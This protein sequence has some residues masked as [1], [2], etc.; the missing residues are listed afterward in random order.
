MEANLGLKVCWACLTP[1]ITS[2][3]TLLSDDNG[4]SARKLYEVTGFKVSTFAIKIS[5]LII[6]ELQ[7]CAN[8]DSDAAICDTC[9]DVLNKSD[10]LRKKI[11]ISENCYF[12]PLRE[13]RH[14]AETEQLIVA[15]DITEASTGR[16]PRVLNGE[17]LGSRGDQKSKIC[18]HCN[19][20]FCTVNVA[21][22]PTS[23]F[24]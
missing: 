4:E 9:S 3:L 18:V 7:L 15:D 23:P 11:W 24:T 12:Q 22:Q 10:E 13:N 19:K 8:A 16:E 2:R 1:K 6:N 14:N 17:T 21:R 5:S 20:T